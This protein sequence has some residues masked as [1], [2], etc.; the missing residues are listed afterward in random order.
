MKQ[1]SS[2]VSETNVMTT[3]CGK[4]GS[5]ATT[6]KRA[7]YVSK[8]FPLVMPVEYVVD[9]DKKSVVCSHTANAAEVAELEV[10]LGSLSCWN[11]AAYGLSLSRPPR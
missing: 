5:L 6:K 11:T 1:V 8:K 3:F 10:C 2:A 4:V 7:S 9:K